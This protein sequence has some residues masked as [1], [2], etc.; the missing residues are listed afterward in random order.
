MKP[1]VF[2][3]GLRF[4]FPLMARMQWVMYLSASGS[5]SVLGKTPQHSGSFSRPPRTLFLILRQKAPAF[6]VICKILYRSLNF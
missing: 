3:A 5:A 6:A 4:P 1:G 2:P